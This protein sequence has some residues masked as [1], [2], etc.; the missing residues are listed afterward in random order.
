M[1]AFRATLMLGLA[2]AV[3]LGLQCLSAP[4][5]PPPVAHPERP[6]SASDNT[7]DVWFSGTATLEADGT[8]VVQIASGEKGQPAAHGYFRY[9]PAHPEYSR[10]SEHVGQLTVGAPKTIEPWPPEERPK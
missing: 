5:Q 3:L 8:I 2:A 4:R 1:I 6:G 9:P 7:S 10:I